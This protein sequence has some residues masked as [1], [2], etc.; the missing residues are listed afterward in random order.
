ML[1]FANSKQLSCVLHW[2]EPSV[3]LRGIESWSSC[4]AIKPRS[5][6]GFSDACPSVNCS[7][8]TQ[9]L[10]SSVS[11]YQVLVTSHTKALLP[12]L[13]SS[14]R[15][16]ALGR[17]LVV[18]NLFLLRIMEDTVLMGIF[19]AAEMFLYRSSDLCLAKVLQTVSLTSWFFPAFSH[20]CKHF[21]MCFIYMYMYT[22]LLLILVILY[23]I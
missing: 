21:L 13:L 15:R 8:S 4:S 18:S 6:E 16:P 12:R 23:V 10:W 22:F 1:L 3:Q 2:G 17:V 7:M 5:V 11:D 9:N 20:G 19:S 14:A